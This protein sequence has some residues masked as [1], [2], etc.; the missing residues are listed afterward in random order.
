MKKKLLLVSLC[1]IV[2]FGFAACG[3]KVSEV[4]KINFEG[5]E[6]E[7]QYTGWSV[8]D[9]SLVEDDEESL[10]PFILVYFNFTNKDSTGYSVQDCYGITVYQ[11]GVE[12]D[13]S[14]EYLNADSES[15]RAM[16]NFFN[17]VK[18][19]GTLPIAYSCY[20]SNMSGEIEVEVEE[21]ETGK[22]QNMIID[23]SK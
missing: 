19:G 17:S 20:V 14:V 22:T 7:L 9:W 8:S 23:L 15:Y 4:E 13:S 5:S 16:D 3:S 10:E 6:Q 1:A 18:G 11:E 2:A 21:Y 12:Q